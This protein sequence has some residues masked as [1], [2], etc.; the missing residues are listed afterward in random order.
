VSFREVAAREHPEHFLGQFQEAK[1]IRDGRLRPPHALRDI[2][3]RQLE[4]V[5]KRRVRTRLLDWGEL[6][7]G[8]VLDE[9]EEK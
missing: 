3:Q 8:D 7:A 4:L 6:F 9:P 1:A 5:D 2:A